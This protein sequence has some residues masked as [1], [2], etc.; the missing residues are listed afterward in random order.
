MYLARVGGEVRANRLEA[1]H[2]DFTA[3]M[4]LIQLPAT[5]PV[6]NYDAGLNRPRLISDDLTA[7]EY[8]P[9]SVYFP[10]I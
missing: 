6:L 4:R 8:K 3:S 7:L 10:Y 1:T 5:T 2:H 9:V